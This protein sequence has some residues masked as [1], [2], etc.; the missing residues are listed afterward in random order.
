M[1]V[2]TLSKTPFF[3]PLGQCSS[4]TPI[5]PCSPQQGSQARAD[6]PS[7]GVPWAV[8]CLGGEAEER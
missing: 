1:G 3:N 2:W 5:S 6:L 7:L 4:L 8:G